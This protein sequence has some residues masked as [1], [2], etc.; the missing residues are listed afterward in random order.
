MSLFE[1]IAR[2]FRAESRRRG[3]ELAWITPDWAI[4][5]APRRQGLKR[6]S[7]EGVAAIVDLRT[8]AHIDPDEAAAAGLDVFRLPVADGAAPTQQQLI[9]GVAWVLDQTSRGNRVLICCRAGRGRSV[10]LACSV[11]LQMGYP[12]QQ[13]LLLVT[14]VRSTAQ[15]SDDQ[16]A[17]LTQ[18]AAARSARRQGM[19]RQGAHNLTRSAGASDRPPLDGPARGPSN[20]R[21]Q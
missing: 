11:L 9:E 8:E 2:W 6:L 10:T 16:V 12:L 20:T 14:Q 13:A 1:R 5:P 19:S 18:F 15:L 17:A 7:R 4:G 21:R 3:A